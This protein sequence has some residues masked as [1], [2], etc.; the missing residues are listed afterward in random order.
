MKSSSRT[1]TLERGRELLRQQAWSH[2]YSHLVAADRESPL[3]P[4][5]LLDLATISRLLGKEETAGELLTRAHQ[6][7]LAQGEPQRAARCA[8][9]LGFLAL[10]NTGPAQAGGWFSRAGR[11]LERQES[12]VEHGY[13]LLASGYRLISERDTEAAYKVFG[14]AVAIGERFVDRDLVALG[15]QAQGRALIRQGEIARGVSLLD[16][17][18]VAV[19]TGEVSP[20]MAG[21]IYC[22]VIDS[23][24]ETFDLGRAQEWTA[25]LDQW[26]TSQPDIVPYR[27]HCM[28]QRAEI[29]QLRGAWS[30][31]LKEAQTAC[32]KLAQP[33]PKPTLAGAY[34]R[35]AELHRLRGEF[36]QA[37]EAYRHAGHAQ[38][39]YARLRLAQGQVDVAISAIRRMAEEVH[40]L[41][42]RAKVLDA[43][44]E[45]AL[46]SND[47]ADA[48][49]SADEL[50]KIAKKHGAS[51]LQAMAARANGA[52]LLAE[53]DPRKA[54]TALRHSW[55]TWCKL[56]AP[57]EAARTRV[58]I[59]QACREQGDCD[60][61]DMELSSA[62]EVF[63]QL[64][65]VCELA[66][67]NSLPGKNPGADTGLTARETEVLRL[68]AS[69]ST[70]RGIALKLKIS[71]KTVAR[72][73]SNIFNKLDLNS[74]SA[75]T[76][77]AY[78]HDL[79]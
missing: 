50:T 55:I 43:Y 73:L 35:V 30:D 20:F 63:E 72:H 31:A 23:C 54:L 66:R 49:A 24:Q 47:I 68:V 53:G 15:L 40:E 75:A 33:T 1:R 3:D 79:V 9:W 45:I 27:S 76:A 16:E 61:A 29:M 62:R 10:F 37:E 19:T 71:E 77:Y 51:L 44:V 26:C 56:E 60:S 57:Y 38:P 65:A 4:E 64:G 8:L 14:Q 70:N 7:F 42:N 36:A 74:R 32:E 59:A 17:A 13:L 25:A 2:A 22:A 69:G 12:C 39:G 28:L 48:R 52:V 34:Y 67:L 18:M 46:E 5:D 11:L 58:W 41:G 78:E 21:N 6:G